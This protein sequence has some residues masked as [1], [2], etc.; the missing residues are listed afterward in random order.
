VTRKKSLIDTMKWLTAISLALL[1]VAC[2]SFGLDEEQL[3]QRAKSYLEDEQYQAA[4]IEARNTLQ[5]NPQNAEA[6]Y[7]LGVITL[8][9]G[10]YIT[11]EREFRRAD[12]AGW[13]E[14]AARVGRARA[15]LELGEYQLLVEQITTDEA[16]AGTVNADLLALRAAASAGLEDY[17][18]S[19]A[20][21]AEATALDPSAFQVYMTRV[22][23]QLDDDDLAAAT[24]IIRDALE[25]YPKNPELLLLQAKID[26]AEGNVTQ[27]KQTLHR[28]IEADPE[29]F[30]SIYNVNARLN[31]VEQLILEDN[32]DEAERY[33]APLYG[34]TRNAP[35]TNY[36]GGLL[37]F[38]QGEYDLAEQ[39]L[40]KVLKVAPDHAP[41]RLLFAT[42][43]FAQQDYEQAAYFLSKY[44]ATN[45]DH[46][47]AR[48]LLGRSYMQLDQP[49]EARR[50]L[51]PALVDDTDD[52]EL[53]MLVGLSALRSGDAAAGI[54][55]LERA[56]VLES[57]KV[58][59]RKELASVYM[60]TGET[61]IAIQ[62]LQALIDRGGDEQ[63]ALSIIGSLRNGEFERAISASLGLLSSNPADPVV[64]SLAGNVFAASGDYLEARR[65]LE[66]AL[67]IKPDFYPASIAMAR[68]EE[69]EGNIDRAVTLYRSLDELDVD[70]VVPVLALARLEG[71]QG[72]T[73][74]V[75]DLLQSASEDFPEESRP[76]LL[77]AEHYLREKQYEKAALLLDEAQHSDPDQ[78]VVLYMQAR[79]L[80]STERYKRAIITLEDL[81]EIDPESTIARVLL[82]E[83]HLY[84][85]SLELAKDS[86]KAVLRNAPN[87]LSALALMTKIEL[88][89]GNLDAAMRY[90]QRIQDKH[91]TLYLGY[92]LQGD[93][94]VKKKNDIAAGR[95]FDLAW[96]RMRRSELAIR[97]AEVA[98][99]M[100]QDEVAVQSLLAWLSDHPGDARVR[101][102]L[103]TTYL[104]MGQMDMAIA[105][106]KNVLAA[107]ASDV[108]ALNNLALIYSRAGDR[109]ARN[110]AERAY[111]VAPGNPAVLDTYGW[112]LLQQGEVERGRK[113]LSEASRQLPDEA[114]VSYH[115]AVALLKSGDRDGARQ[116][117]EA[118]VT[119]GRSFEG[120]EQARQL[121]EEIT[122]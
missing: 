86:L 6:R 104:E 55:G 106:Y 110:M 3:L 42:V 85:G 34:R 94:W 19:T 82:A 13:G 109:Q 74:R 65:Y 27:G 24:A 47:A 57:N 33:L 73:G 38:E 87:D 101:R 37:A 12:L 107:N 84:T 88:V 22:Q 64:I 51:Q 36:L 100:E 121:L 117:L 108:A 58:S 115:F 119:G 90:S 97:Q 103:A 54:E 7:L 9:Y 114:E 21:L 69:L 41:S 1:L 63:A 44:M 56:L 39:R 26:L 81:L 111:R 78:P 71:Q 4:A 15:M 48:K 91:P 76:Q 60:T 28:V 93:V 62:E 89:S 14:G 31:L 10:D 122:G 32:L 102:F 72:N 30:V 29:G 92:L 5:K 8:E 46:V 105:E 113:L 75:V 45:P 59:L 18:R 16:F 35:Y 11:A 20:I 120:S 40:L 17:D 49:G 77:L 23:L 118:L 67:T 68:L 43:N 25:R 50:A 96:E 52:A 99:R 98:L 66:Q 2:G 116:I 95:Q 83:A 53:L 80:I 61:S 79:L 112:I 70:S